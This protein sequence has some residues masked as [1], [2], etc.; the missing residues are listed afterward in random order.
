MALLKKGAYCKLYL[1][2]ND[3]DEGRNKLKAPAR[4][5]FDI[6][7]LQF[8][9]CDI[10][11]RFLCRRWHRTRQADQI[12]QQWYDAAVRHQT[13]HSIRDMLREN[14]SPVPAPMRSE[15]SHTRIVTRDMLRNNRVPWQISTTHPATYS[16]NGGSHLL[17]LKS[18]NEWPVSEDRDCLI[19]L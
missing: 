7:D 2:E 13:I 9:L 15:T 6:S 12:G 18:F 4:R 14:S 5:P 10:A 3:I 19:C 11:S 17:Q 8:I 1:T 16:V